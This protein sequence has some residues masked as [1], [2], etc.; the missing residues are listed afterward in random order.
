LEKDSSPEFASVDVRDASALAALASVW[1]PEIILHLA[2]RG[3]VLAP[4]G[5]LPEMLDVAVDGLLHLLRLFKPKKMIFPS[6]CAVYGDTQMVAASP[7]ASL[8]PLGVYGL[9][10]VMGER[11]LGEWADETRNTAVVLRVGN[12]VGPGGRGL[13]PYLTNHALRY[14]DGNP[15]AQMRGAGRIVRDYVP[16]DYAVRIFEW[17]IAEEWSPGEAHTLN[18]G[19]GKPRTNGEVAAIVQQTLRESGIALKIRF[20]DR[21]GAGESP[22]AILDT[23]ETEKR[24]GIDPPTEFEVIRAIRESVHF[25][26]DRAE[27]T[28]SASA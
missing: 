4:F 21:P 10:K 6:S 16:I 13:V 20:Q 23:H 22:C 17:T 8:N 3:A 27:A 24:L 11:I 28:K 12:L 7:S 5:L 26:M 2:S 25:C 15:P 19:S 14:P 9:S 18:L 1:R